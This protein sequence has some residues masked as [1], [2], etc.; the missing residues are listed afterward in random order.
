VGDSL[1]NDIIG[2]INA[3]FKS[4]WLNRKEIESNVNSEIKYEVKSLLEL[5]EILEY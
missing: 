3:G 2:A 4:V 1:Q 5:L